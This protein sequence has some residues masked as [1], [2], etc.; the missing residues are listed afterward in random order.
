MQY[1]KQCLINV[2]AFH[3]IGLKFVLGS[4]LLCFSLSSLSGS[5]FDIENKLKFY[6]DTNA[7][8]MQAYKHFVPFH[9]IVDIKC[10]VSLYMH[11]FCF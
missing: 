10:I 8:E 9:L 4:R 3:I 1:Y 5:V 2:V 7:H 6:Q 11:A